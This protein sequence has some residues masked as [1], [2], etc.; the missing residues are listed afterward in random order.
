MLGLGR[1]LEYP[2]LFSDD[3]GIPSNVALTIA[4]NLGTFIFSGC[5]DESVRVLIAVNHVNTW[6]VVTSNGA[7]SA[8]GDR[9]NG[10]FSCIFQRMDS[11]DGTTVL[12]EVTVNLNPYIFLFSNTLEVDGQV[13][14]QIMLSPVDATS[15]SRS[16][17]Y[18]CG[19]PT[20]DLT[21][22]GGADITDGGDNAGLY[23]VKLTL[24]VPGH[25][26]SNQATTGNR[27]IDAA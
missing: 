22:L 6:K 15:I 4:A 9:L 8:Q 16:Q 7:I 5:D 24:S 27:T 10:T 18:T 21:D 20:I 17:Y 23:R 12:E 19:S 26:D 1:G 2:D 25:I 3:G 13:A 14:V 11:D